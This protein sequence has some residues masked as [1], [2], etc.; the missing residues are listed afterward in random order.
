MKPTKKKIT[1]KTKKRV[2]RF[3]PLLRHRLPKIKLYGNKSERNELRRENKCFN[4]SKPRSQFYLR[5]IKIKNTCNNKRRES[6]EKTRGRHIC[7]CVKEE[8]W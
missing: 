5:S 2:T 6:D 4:P 7:V 1:T 8:K 3:L